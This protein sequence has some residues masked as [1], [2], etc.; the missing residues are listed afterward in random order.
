MNMA[1]A[2]AI[3]AIAAIWVGIAAVGYLVVKGA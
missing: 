2:L 3:A 1:I